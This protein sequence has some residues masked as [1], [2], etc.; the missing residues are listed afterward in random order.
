MPLNPSAGVGSNIKEL[1]SGKTFEHTKNKFG[2]ERAD[3][4]SIAIA[5]D[6]AR[7][8]KRAKG[9]KI[10]VGAIKGSDPGRTDTIPMKVEDSS[11]VLPADFISHLGENNSAS[12]LKMA[13]HL[14]GEGGVHDEPSQ[15]KSGGR[16]SKGKPVECITASGEFVVPPSVIKN[17]GHGDV[18]FGHR[19][20]DKLVMMMREDHVKTLKALPRP[21]TD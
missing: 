3:K 20:M 12:G 17:I 8:A 21:A 7:K 19:I 18:D 14:Y 13:Q 15:R 2:K 1:H 6:V 10:H 11:Y 4:Q 16:T 5:L 9:G